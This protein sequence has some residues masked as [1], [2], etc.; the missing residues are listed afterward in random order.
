M[1]FLF[2]KP[3]RLKLISHLLFTFD[4]SFK[5]DVTLWAFVEFY[6]QQLLKNPTLL[7]KLK[8]VVLEPVFRQICWL[9]IRILLNKQI[10]TV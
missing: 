2:P 1:S 4:K 3:S 6:K 7:S 10:M 8:V 5:K 9:F